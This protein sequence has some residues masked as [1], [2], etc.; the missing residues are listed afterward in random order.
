MLTMLFAAAA[1]AP[2]VSGTLPSPRVE[3][4]DSVT[5]ML[6]HGGARPQPPRQPSPRWRPRPVAP[7]YRVEPVPA[8]APADM[9]LRRG[10]IVIDTARHRL[11]FASPSGQLESYPVAVGKQ[12][13]SWKGTAV[14][15][16]KVA[17]PTWRPTAHMRANERLPSVVAPGRHN[18]LGTR[19]LYLYR[20]GRDTMFRIHGTNAPWSIGKSVSHGCIRMLNANVEHLYDQVRLG[21]RV[22]VR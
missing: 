6:Q 1:L 13:A 14:V 8:P 9:A 15:G 10:D 7:A 17:F 16:R 3:F 20:N 19:A 4:D 5:Y 2:Q 18:P 11:T 12:G 21:A 22:T